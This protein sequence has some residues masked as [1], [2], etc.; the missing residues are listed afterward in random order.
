MTISGGSTY[1]FAGLP[2]AVLAF[3]PTAWLP[4]SVVAIVSAGVSFAA[5]AWIIGRLGLAWWW[6][7]FPPL[8]MG[9]L[10]AN[11]GVVLLA[12]LLS[13]WPPAE[14]LA[15]ALKVYAILP[16]LAERRWRGLAA[17]G[18]IASPRCHCGWNGTLP[19]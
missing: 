18:L 17:F 1:H 2:P 6:L 7:L 5:G 10:S 13:R 19:G 4:E 14:G 8:V 16:M 12:L 15:G 9:A 11:P 3:V